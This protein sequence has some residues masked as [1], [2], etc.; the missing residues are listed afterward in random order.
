M[1]V[2]RVVS[3]AAWVEVGSGTRGAYRSPEFQSNFKNV[4]R[5]T[6]ARYASFPVV[7]LETDPV[8]TSQPNRPDNVTSSKREE[9]AC[10]V[11]NGVD[12]SVV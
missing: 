11:E 9:G 1:Q 8:T 4:G 12:E 10:S 3:D 7:K 6:R 5:S 2:R